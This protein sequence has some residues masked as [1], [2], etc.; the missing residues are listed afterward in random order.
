MR[1]LVAI[2]LAATALVITSTAAAA[3]QS[4]VSAYSC[5]L[6]GGHVYR[7]A[8][9]SIVA[10]LGWAAKNTGL[11]QEYLKSQTTTFSVNGGDPVDVSNSYGDIAEYAGGGF[12]SWV[13]YDTGAVLVPGENMTFR[14]VLSVAHPSLDGLVFADGEKGR[15]LF[16]G[17][18]TLL[19]VSCTVTGS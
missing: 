7:P 17:A 2:G 12:V 3:D 14:T 10:R 19:D 8:G 15:P 11:V 1:I 18:G 5:F 16:Y 13:N 6:Q 4:L 9:T